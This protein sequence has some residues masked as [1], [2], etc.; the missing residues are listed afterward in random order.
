MAL[1]PSGF[2]GA[3]I[4]AMTATAVDAQTVR[5]TVVAAAGTTPIANAS[6]VARGRGT[7][8]TSDRLGRFTIAT[9]APDTLIITAIGWRPDTIPVTGTDPDPITSALE[10]APV[11][12]SDLIAT[13]P[14]VRPLDLS[15]HGRWEMPMAAAR[16]VP[17]AVETDVYRALAM[18]PAVSFS[19]PLSA[20]PLMRGYDAQEVTTR[21][22]GFEVLNLY[23]LGRIFSSFPADAAEAI[24]VSAAPYT[25]AHGG[26]TAGLIDVTGR[27]GRLD[28]FE[29]GGGLSYGSLSGF[30]GGGNDRLRSFGTARVFYWKS[31]ELIPNL[32]IPYHFEDLY[33]GLVFGP[34]ERPTG[35]LTLFATQDQAGPTDGERTF[36]HWDN[37]MLGGRWRLKDGARTTIEVST[38][39]AHFGQ[40]GEDVPGLHSIANANLKNRFTRLAVTADLVSVFA[41]TRIATGF[42]LGW[43]NVVNQIVDAPL[44]FQPDPDPFGAPRAAIDAGRLE[45]GGYGSLSRRV[46]PFTLE[47]A[48]RV[49]AAGAEA[50]VE[51]RVHARWAAAKRLELSAGVGRTSRL[52]HLLG[53]ARAE[54]D[55]DFL[56][57][58]LPAGDSVPTARVDHATLD[59]NAEFAPFIGRVSVFASAGKGIGELTPET[60]QRQLGPFE[61]F[62]FGRS[63]TRGIEAQIAYRG[64]PAAPHSLSLSYVYSRSDRD[65]GEGWVRWSLDRT[66]QVRGFGQIRLGGITWFGAVDAATGSPITPIDF[67]LDA[68]AAPGV[69][70]VVVP[71]RAVPLAVYGREN[72]AATSGTFRVDLGLGY[73]FGGPNHRRFTLGASVINLLATAVSPFGY[74]AGPG[75]GPMALDPLGGSTP[76]RRLFSLPPIPTVTLRV[77]F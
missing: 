44:D 31:L 67:G 36:L 52:Y 76:Y 11:I 7:A 66:H 51:P 75:E 4:A 58:W 60:T 29:A 3:A 72:T 64:A 46:G 40:Q 2:L 53:E 17:P 42:A 50:S 71:G 35:R 32:D 73:T 37:V 62:R 22:D 6:I 48:L 24:T 74:S 18:I 38:S 57:F 19:S 9:M 27:T 28:R 1:R 33:G 25:A 30:A 47:A 68:T 49:D 23:H 45:L 55:F 21:I 69:P 61:F 43:R 26:S 54:P 10:R 16:T 13:A 65:W 34:A 8:T 5:G 59:L 39:A 15:D 12:I 20:R 70:A 56:D 63:R 77:E 14:A 41:R